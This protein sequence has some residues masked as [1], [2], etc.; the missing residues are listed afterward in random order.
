MA[1]A[2]FS[3]GTLALAYYNYSHLQQQRRGVR[4]IAQRAHQMSAPYRRYRADHRANRII[5]RAPR[6]WRKPVIAQSAGSAALCCKHVITR[7]AALM[8][9]FAAYRFY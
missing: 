9:R 4:V 8:A 2:A 6:I 1:A 3:R 7:R 5:G